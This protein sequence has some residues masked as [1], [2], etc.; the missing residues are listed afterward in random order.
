MSSSTEH[1]ALFNYGEVFINQSMNVFTISI[2]ILKKY[3]P[4]S[5]QK[6]NYLYPLI[7]NELLYIK[8]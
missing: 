3:S 8:K 5:Y 6:K 4:S 1:I 7:D 2:Y